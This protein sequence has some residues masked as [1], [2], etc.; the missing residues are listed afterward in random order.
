[1]VPL[2]SPPSGLVQAPDSFFR[3]QQREIAFYLSTTFRLH[4]IHFSGCL[5]IIMMHAMLMTTPLMTRFENVWVDFFFRNRPSIAMHPAIVHI[6]MAEDSLQGLGRWPWARYNHAAMVHIL[7][8]WGAKAIVFDVIFS[9]PSTSFDDEALAQA[10]KE[11]GNVYLPVTLE[12]LGHQKTWVHSMPEFE[13]FAKGIGH[14]NIFPDSDG[15]IRRA[16]PL[17]TYAG[18]TYTYLGAK[19]ALDYLGRDSSK[20]KIGIP[21]DQDGNVFINWVGKWKD[22]FQH[23]S[24]LDVI[25]SYAEIQAGRPPLISPEKFK[26][27]ICVIGLTAIGLTDIKANPMEEAY[28][29]VGVQTNIMNSILTGQFAQPAPFRWNTIALWGIGIMVSFFFIFSRRAASLVFGLA[30]GFLW[31][32]FS[33]WIFADRGIWM[34]TMS[35]LLLIFSLF[36]FSAIFSITIGK[37]E[38][39]RL[40]ALATRDGLTG[41]YVIRH[42][43]NLLNAAV[44]EAHKKGLPLSVVLLDLDH[45]KSINDKYGHVTGDEALRYVAQILRGVTRLEGEPEE[46]NPIGRYGGEEFIIMFRKYHLI[47]AAFNYAEKIRRRFEEESFSHEGV[48]IPFT[49]SLGVATLWPDETVPDLMVLRADEALYRAKTEGRNRVCVEKKSEESLS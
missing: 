28:P 16:H 23:Y 48:R 22:S 33:F 31:V 18:K 42:F 24:Y 17:L 41:L 7:H 2:K 19:V 6:D 27:K 29:A 8:L 1:M 35:P 39:A 43:R 15:T 40:F 9:E 26:N 13:D 32:L 38:Q 11:A 30:L 37:R 21:L 4:L 10:V 46:L 5:L 49:V 45:F 25:K 44:E 36:V 34:Y 12:T 20:G 3:R 14:V 47:D